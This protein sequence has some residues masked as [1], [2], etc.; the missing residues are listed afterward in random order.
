MELMEKPPKKE[1]DWKADM[2]DR[3]FKNECARCIF[4]RLWV[5]KQMACPKLPIIP[6]GI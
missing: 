3:K 1:K 2:A 6:S 5:K 4:V